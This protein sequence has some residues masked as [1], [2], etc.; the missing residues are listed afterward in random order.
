MRVIQLTLLVALSLRAAPS[1]WFVARSPHFEIYSDAG[2]ESATRSLARFEELRFFFEHYQIIQTNTFPR[3]RPPIRVVAFSSQREY[4]GFKVRPTADAYY[5]ATEDRDYIVLPVLENSRSFAIAAHEYAHSVLYSRSLKLPP[6]LSEGIAELFSTVTVTNRRFEFGGPL[7]ARVDVLRHQQWLPASYLFTREPDAEQHPT[8]ETTALFYA[9]SWAIVDMLDSASAYTPHFA[10]L[11]AALNA[12]PA[13]SLSAIA[14]VYG[15][16]PDAVLADAKVW[17]ENGR[18]SRRTFPAFSPEKFPVSLQRLSEDQSRILIADLLFADGEW[19]RSEQIYRSLLRQSPENPDL[20]ASLGTLALRRSRKDEAADYFRRA[21]DKH[22]QD[23]RLCY[24]YALLADELDMPAKEIERALERAISIQPNY[25]EARYKLALLE[26]NEGEYAAAVNN[27]QLMEKPSGQRAFVY[28]VALSNALSE[29]D[30]RDEAIFAADQAMRFA[31]TSEERARA[32]QLAY[33][34]GTD[35]TVRFAR[36]EK[37]NLQLMTTRVPHGTS[38]FNPFVE[39][40]DHI[41]TAI[42]ELKEVQCTEGRLTGLLVESKGTGTLA[43]SIPD[44]L[45]VMIKN[46]PSQFYCGPQLARG[47]K[48]EYA[49]AAKPASGLLRGMEFQ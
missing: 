18:S 35:L 3:R 9:E 24:R 1:H 31:T 23:A 28:W 12:E 30:R 8:R 11:V 14:R 16:T 20:L 7:R 5:T 6:W 47:V 34:A 36:D 44:P 10:E 17:I 40:G 29:L 41:E 38:D 25:D 32:T 42:G 33:V 19:T 39:P 4:E 43:L 48:V 26:S 37:G 49:A 46:G 22:L 15:K 13:T 2:P 45:H 27:L 21:L